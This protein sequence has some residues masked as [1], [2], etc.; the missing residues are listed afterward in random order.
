M[1]GMQPRRC[2]NCLIHCGERLPKRQLQTLWWAR[3]SIPISSQIGNGR[4]DDELLHARVGGVTS[5]SGRKGEDRPEVLQR[6]ALPRSSADGAASGRPSSLFT[7]SNRVVF[8]PGTRQS[9]AAE[10]SLLGFARPLVVTDSGLVASGMVADVVASIATAVLFQDVQ[11]NPTEA[12]VL[13]GLDRYR[14][15]QCDG[16]ISLGGGSAIDAAKAIRLLVCHPPRSIHGRFR[17]KARYRDEP[18]PA[19]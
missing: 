5:L 12:D 18:L 15:A 14:N 8:G 9:L 1:K 13:A 17:D 2:N 7:F 11:A 4:P 6:S 16:L 3:T 19:N 10:L